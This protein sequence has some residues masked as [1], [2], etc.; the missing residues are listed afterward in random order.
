MDLI[1]KSL[2]GPIGEDEKKLIRKSM[3]WF[4]KHLANNSVMTI[5]IK[6]HIIKKSN[7][8]YEVITHINSPQMKQPVYVKVFRNSLVEAVNVSREK[9]E[10]IVVKDKEQRKIKFK[11]PKL[12]F[13]KKKADVVIS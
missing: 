3:L 11:L 1:I 5:G 12:K 4:E 2:A 13:G 9:I 7:Q 10:R 6:Q 8:A